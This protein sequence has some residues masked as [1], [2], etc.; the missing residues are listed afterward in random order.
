MLT[1]C[2][3]RAIGT[4]DLYSGEPGLKWRSWDQLSW[5]ILWQSSITPGKWR[6]GRSYLTF[7]HTVSFPYIYSSLFDG[8][9]CR[10]DLSFSL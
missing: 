9:F 1:E 6:K 3:G 10:D 2:R 7:G 8:K 5:Q 4:P